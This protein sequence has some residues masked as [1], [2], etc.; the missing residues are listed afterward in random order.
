M[1]VRGARCTGNAAGMHGRSAACA[2]RGQ[3]RGRAGVRAGRAGVRGA[4]ACACARAGTR[5]CTGVRAAGASGSL[6]TRE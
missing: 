1:H 5:V 6:F 3:A 4:R 2:G